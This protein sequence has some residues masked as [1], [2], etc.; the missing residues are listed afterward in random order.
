MK[1]IIFG[2]PVKV[3]RVKNLI[4]DQGKH[5]FYNPNDFTISVDA[6]EKGEIL[7]HTLIHEMAHAMSH[8]IGILQGSIPM[9]V[10]EIIAEA[11]ATMI[12]ENFTLTPKR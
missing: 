7:H 1:L 11:F 8:R 9:D 12:V 5:A 10:Q 4:A 3:N 6:S 2:L